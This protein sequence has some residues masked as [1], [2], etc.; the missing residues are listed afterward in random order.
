MC[1]CE[2]GKFTSRRRRSAVSRHF[3]H[4]LYDRRIY[5]IVGLYTWKL[6]TYAVYVRTYVRRVR[7]SPTLREQ[8]WREVEW[9]GIIREEKETRRR[10]WKRNKEKEEKKAREE[11]RG[12]ENLVL[13]SKRGRVSIVLCSTC[14]RF[15][16]L[17][18]RLLSLR[19][20][21]SFHVTGLISITSLFFEGRLSPG[22]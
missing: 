7:R 6:L 19:D 16:P 1:E 14:R 5:K 2:R 15:S 4:R 9:N 12:L 22:L 13:T 8:L 10:R 17:L 3:R 18:R 11:S 21:A 20:G